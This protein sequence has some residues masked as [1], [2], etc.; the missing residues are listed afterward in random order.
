MG[1]EPGI[2]ESARV[3]WS[4]EQGHCTSSNLFI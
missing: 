1:I 2:P 3:T 4:P